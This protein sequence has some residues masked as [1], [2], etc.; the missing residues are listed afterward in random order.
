MR[1]ATRADLPALAALMDRSA[2]GLCAGFYDDVQTASVRTH[3]AVVDRSLID[4]G[5]YFVIEEGGGAVACGGW[6]RRR[7]L[8]TGGGAAG[9]DGALLDPRHEPAKVRAMFV[10]PA[11]ARRG[12]GRAILA[13]C[14]DAARAAGFTRVELMATLPG[15]PLYAACGY[16]V[17]E[18]VELTLPD[19]VRIG[20]AR[21]DRGL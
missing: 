14:E 13:A 20:A 2:Q 4:D 7:K 6:S 16:Q 17:L 8:F 21:M 15:E 5:T 18:R 12:F 1:L 3:I 11:W 9:D 19:G 10:D